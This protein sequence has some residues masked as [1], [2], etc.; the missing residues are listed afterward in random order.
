MKYLHTHHGI[1]INDLVVPLDVKNAFNCTR[2]DN[3][4]V[5]L[6]R[7]VVLVNLERMVKS[8]FENR[9]LKCY[10]DDGMQEYFHHRKRAIVIRSLKHCCAYL[11]RCY[12]MVQILTL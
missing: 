12:A 1:K 6:D 7:L 4:R 5:A 10:S 9:Y 11:G 8:Y 3:I 2:W